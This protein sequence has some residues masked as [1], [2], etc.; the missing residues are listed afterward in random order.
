[1]RGKR[2]GAGPESLRF[3]PQFRRIQSTLTPA[4]FTTF[5]HLAMSAFR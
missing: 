5:A 3:P 2:W 1:M 4:V